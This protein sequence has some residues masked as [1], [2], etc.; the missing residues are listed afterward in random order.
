MISGEQFL[1]E[2]RSTQP[3]LA[4]LLQNI[5]DGV[6]STATQLGVNPNGK[7]SAPPAPEKLSVT[8]NNGTVQASITHNAPIN[9]QIQYHLEV[10]TNPS[11]ATA[12]VIHLVD[13]RSWFG[14]LPGR[15]AGANNSTVAQ[16]WYFRAYAQYNGSDPS[17][18][19]YLG[20]SLNPT[21]VTVGGNGT[22][23]PLASTGSG[24]AAPNGQQPG[25]GLG[26]VQIRA[27]VGPKRSPA[28]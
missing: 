17:E 24:T 10:D 8:A 26:P 25:T 5:I 18:K 28:Q 22:F 21:P 2:L 15:M 1:K 7:V 6:N 4:L 3:H 23:V 14:S 27:A 9:K 16:P 13:S 20:D 19:V 12:H 11:F